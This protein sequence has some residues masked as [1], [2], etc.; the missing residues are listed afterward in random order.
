[1][2]D[3]SAESCTALAQKHC[4][5]NHLCNGM[6]DIPG[7]LLG[8]KRGQRLDSG[9]YTPTV[10]KST[11]LRNTC[12]KSETSNIGNSLSGHRS[13]IVGV[14]VKKFTMSAEDHTNQ[15]V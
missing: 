10:V 7:R 12:V 4:S 15:Q 9:K 3:E 2:L 6:L 1:M 8:R 13:S 5:G 14:S 11:A